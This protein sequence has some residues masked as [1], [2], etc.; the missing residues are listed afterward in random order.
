MVTSKVPITYAFGLRDRI[1]P[2][3]APFG[4][5]K[6][7]KNLRVRK[8]GRLGTRHGYQALTMTT[9]NGTLEAFDLHDYKGRLCA[10]GNDAGDDYPTDLFEYVNVGP[11]IWR[12]TDRYGQ[13]VTLNP[14]TN[15]REIAGIPAL[16][17]DVRAAAVAIGG[18]YACLVYVSGGIWAVIVDQE[19]DQ[20]IH[21]EALDE[22]IFAAGTFD[23]PLRAV[24]SSGAF[25]VLA[26][27]IAVPTVAQIGRFRVGV[28][29]AFSAFAS[30]SG[31]PAG[32]FQFS[33]L[34][35]CAVSNPSTARIAVALD[36][37]TNSNLTVR[38]FNSAGAQVGS[39]I[40]ISGTDTDHLSVEADQADNTINL[41]TVVGGVGQ[42][43][44]YNFSASLLAGPTTTTAGAT[45]F[46]CRLPARG[47]FTE[48]IAV[49]VNDAS[50][51]VVIQ[52]F[53]VDTHAL[54]GTT[55][56]QRAV[57]T[58]RAVSGQSES[59][60][61]ALAFPALVGADLTTFEETTNALFFVTPEVG[62]LV[63]R[64]L[65]VARHITS[66]RTTRALSLDEST[67]RVAWM[68][69]RD[70]GSDIK[71]PV[72][73]LL[74]FKSTARRHSAKYGGLLYFAGAT[75][76]VYDGR[77]VS[78]LQFNEIPA[79]L[80]ATPA[81]GSG[82]LFHNATYQYVVHWEFVLAD[83]SVELSPV[84]SPVTVTTGA[85]DEEVS[86]TMTVPHTVRSAMG[87]A[88]YGADVLLVISRTY[89]DDVTKTRDG[90][91]RRAKSSR[92]GAGMANYG[93]TLTLV[94]RLADSDLLDN[95]VVYTQD[96]RGV[97]SAPL[98]NF[99]PGSCS[100]ITATEARLI[101]AGL[102]SE[103]LVQVSKAAF[104][105]EP[106][107]FNPRSN[108]FAIAPEPVVG[109]RRLDSAKL[110]FTRNTILALTGDGPDD[111]GAGELPP[112]V[113]IPT[114]GGLSNAWSFL[115]GP[116]GLWFQLDET[117]LFRIPRGGGSP[118]WEGV[119]VESVLVDYPVIA[120]ACK[121][122]GDNVGVFACNNVAETG[123]QLIVRD[124]RTENWFTDTPYLGGAAVSISAM[125]SFGDTLAYIGDRVVY[126]Q[127]ETSF[128]DGT[129]T[130]IDTQTRTHPLYP[131]GLGG[132]GQCYDL[133]LTGEY[134]GDCRI[135][136]RVSYDDGQNFT[137]L[138]SFELL[139]AD[140]LVVG[141]TIQRRW[142]LPQ[143]ITSSLVVEL[144]VVQGSAAAPTEGFVY[145]QLDVL[146][147]AEDGLR[148]LRPEEMA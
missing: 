125:C 126:A 77:I 75:P 49:L 137:A 89:W 25:Y 104:L 97:N 84:S 14:F 101:T 54:T 90:I 19:T 41:F 103:H 10:L 21:A 43:R 140:G 3:L 37:G 8:D 115:E 133:L 144:S 58:G 99:A 39:T 45:G 107:A 96:E 134:R 22:T 85:S 91:F 27:L 113:E 116:D 62:H 76:S 132:Y 78:E 147:E 81:S 123:A 105:G 63:T 60:T 30:I 23:T 145:N 31:N 46:I 108:F 73:T 66:T 124:F 127:S 61:M 129:A 86:L 93:E 51:N 88:T 11:V 5:L 53:D 6:V 67:G 69:I 38:V 100:Y 112:P 109:V 1:D 42:I 52:Y 139:A 64:D 74:D 120:G 4:V 83:G 2:K 17:S 48:H 95:E 142:A 131:F 57:I 87:D 40:N 146:V 24:Y 130:F 18:G 13:R 135:D 94:D 128:V 80:S 15:A 33:A 32:S 26:S 98:V 114:P 117:K 136:C 7:G 138:S 9:A 34:D 35:M 92:V 119:D 106:F 72:V 102:T 118:T 79:I 50:T 36:Q 141:Q 20:V 16:D 55:T 71:Q 143:D 148:E 122:K 111:I 44:T 121:H 70:P 47:A 29:S 82:D 68:A 65:L 12:G 110:V 56:V 28:D 59:Q